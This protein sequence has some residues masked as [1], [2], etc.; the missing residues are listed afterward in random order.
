MKFLQ[1][2]V[3]ETRMRCVLENDI[4]NYKRVDK[5]KNFVPYTKAQHQLIDDIIDKADE[6]LQSKLGQKLPLQF[7]DLYRNYDDSCKTYS[8]GVVEA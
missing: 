2:D 8:R 1:M 3:D 7:Y 5:K 6:L 4:T